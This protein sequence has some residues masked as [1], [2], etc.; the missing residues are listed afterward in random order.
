M[1][2]SFSVLQMLTSEEAWSSYSRL[3]E[4]LQLVCG[5]SKVNTRTRTTLSPPVLGTNLP[6]FCMLHS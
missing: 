3:V 6:H 1:M 2:V 5:I 4:Q